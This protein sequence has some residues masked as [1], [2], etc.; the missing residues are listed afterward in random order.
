MS[1]LEVRA[2]V[3]RGAYRLDVE[4]AVGVGETVAVLG[5]SGAGKSTLLDVIA[6]LAGVTSGHVRVGG[7]ELT[8]PRQVVAPQRRGVVLLRQDPHLFPHLT[9][10]ENIAFGLRAR[11]TAKTDALAEADEWLAQ[12]GLADV[13]AGDR[14]P[15]E[16]SGGQQQ[17]VALARALAT[18]PD[19]LLLDEPLTA[20]DAETASGVRALLAERL[21]A[22]GTTTVIVTH[23]AVD[24]VALA[25]DIVLLEDGRVTQTVPVRAV[26]AAPAT[27]FGAAVAGVNRVV[28]EIS[29]GVWVA[30]AL[31]VAVTRRTAGTAGRPEPAVALFPPSAVGIEPAA[32]TEPAGP[33]APV[34]RIARLE[35]TPAG[36]RVHTTEPA[37]A[38]DVSVETVAERGLAVGAAVRLSVP[39]EAV[40]LLA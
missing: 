31:R 16:L 7:R 22:T 36:V 13:Q 29:D 11:G 33:G 3:D 6:G 25:G 21:A 37:L 24:A 4:L 1:G 34:A 27:P 14:R 30:G 28:G 38:A 32:G 40:R 9:A 8:S 23:D 2:V 26:L 17:R 39:P 15:R 18:R 20:L 19:V 5:P 12:V 35:Q 10:R